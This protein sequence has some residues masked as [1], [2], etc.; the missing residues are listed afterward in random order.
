MWQH[1][2]RTFK[3]MQIMIALTA[4]AAYLFFGHRPAMAAT[5]Y[6]VMQVGAVAGAAWAAR[7][8]MLLA[9]ARRDSGLLKPR[10]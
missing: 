9:A 8:R 10:R 2:K 5:F 3:G 6:G 4:I 7:L 1:Y